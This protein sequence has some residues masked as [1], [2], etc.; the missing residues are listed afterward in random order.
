MKDGFIKVGAV[1]PSLKVADCKY[2]GEQILEHI[3]KADEL[4]VRLLVFPELCISGAT[5]GDLFF[6]D[7]LLNSCTDTLEWLLEE[8]RDIDVLFLVGM[9]LS[10]KNALYNTAVYCKNGEILVV[11]PK[12]KL[13]SSEM[14][15][16]SVYQEDDIEFLDMGYNDVPFGTQILLMCNTKLMPTCNK[17]NNFIIATEIGAD[18]YAPDA[19]SLSHAA[20]GA[21]VICVPS[22]TCEIAGRSDYR[23]EL[24]KVQ[25]G[26]LHAAFIY[27]EAG[28]DESTQDMV[29]AGHNIIAENG[30]IL[31]ESKLYEHDMI[32][33]EIDIKRL[34][35]ERRKSG[36][37]LECSEQYWQ[38]EV[39]FKMEDTNLTR[40]FKKLPFVPEN[41]NSNRLGDIFMLQA[42]GLRKRLAH[43][44]CKTAVIG[45]SGGLD[46]TLALLVTAKAYDLL[47][48]DRK[49]ILAVTMP[50]FGTTDRTYQNALDLAGS[51]GATL[52]EISIVAS[53]KQ[54]FK[55]IEQD[56]NNHDVTYENA[57]ARERTQILMDVANKCNGMVIGTGD[58]SELALGW[59][60][61][62]GDHMSMYAV[63]SSIPKTLVR[64]LVNW[65]ADNTDEIT[66]AVL[67]DVLK[68][69]VSPELLPPEENGDIAQKTEDI[70]GPYE[71]HDF[72]IYYMLRF[73][74]APK[75]IYRIAVETFKGEYDS[76]TILKWLKTFYRRF[77]TQQF[78]RSCVPDG[79]KVGTVGLSPRG[80]LRMPSDAC[81]TMWMNELEEISE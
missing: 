34:S 43:T 68:T 4:G 19:P 80:D 20:A 49:H 66:A 56:E 1:S 24:M 35:S 7:T 36:Q 38:V 14:R 59:A 71:L 21:T 69:P 72:F 2:N 77:F 55:D 60:T 10:F 18:T 32:I 11:V 45:L 8:T 47:G 53:V 33:T 40:T 41:T 48:M 26:K 42:M 30:R 39:E 27:A 52:H 64:Y 70:V 25:S 67:R 75:K 81:A 63:N 61:Y 5:C 74:Y 29:F 58:L 46:S 78:K 28:N 73:G 51:L 50:G 15:Y 44:N 13:D 54:H 65:Y 16:F 17:M 37:K 62:N 31:V 9:P 6:Q 22:A 76:V 3:K 79:P 57:Q 12:T 23:R